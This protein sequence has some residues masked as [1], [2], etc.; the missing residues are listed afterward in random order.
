MYRLLIVSVLGI[1]IPTVCA[2]EQ[3]EIQRPMV[4]VTC[5]Y[6][7]RAFYKWHLDSIF[8]QQYDNYRVIHIEDA[9][10][11]G[12]PELIRDYVR[13]RGQEHRFTLIVNETRRGAMANFYSAI[14]SCD[15]RAIILVA[16]GDDAF[17]GPHVL[18]YINSVYADPN[19]W[20]TYGQFQEYT[21]GKIGFC[22]QIPPHIVAANK[23]REFP[24]QPSHLRT[25]YAKLFK[26]IAKE[27][28]MYGTD[29]YP[30]TCDLGTMMPMIEMAG[31]RFKFIA[32]V[33]YIYNDRNP[34]SD[35]HVSEK[36]QRDVDRY[37]RSKKRYTRLEKL[38]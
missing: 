35:H 30:M 21:T 20:L 8:E 4:I 11:D 15:D 18:S 19:V 31:E 34:I 38:F 17:N 6:N 1:C 27:D 7:N 16:D 10:T 2:E 5:S 26:S 36:L 33:L 28:L 25:F 24:D 12:S 23:F 13:A 9:S 14:S 32:K 3:K 22:R 37:I 29:F